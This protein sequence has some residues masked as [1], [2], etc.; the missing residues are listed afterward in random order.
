MSDR[1]SNR[2]LPAPQ[3]VHLF[4]KNLP[5]LVSG[6]GA[7]REWLWWAGPKPSEADRAAL[8]EIGFRFTPVAHTLDDG[9]A[10]KWYHSCGGAVFK[11]RHGDRASTARLPKGTR[12]GAEKSPRRF[13]PPSPELENLQHLADL[14]P[15]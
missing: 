13:I 8:S 12:P 4:Q 7:D 9:R 2:D 1:N 6:L 11:R 3:V 10:A 5:H 14:F 15:E